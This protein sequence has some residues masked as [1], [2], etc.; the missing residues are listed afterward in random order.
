MLSVN[1]HLN[2]KEKKNEQT[3]RPC[4]KIEKKQKT[5]RGS[6]RRQFIPLF[7]VPLKPFRGT[8]ENGCMK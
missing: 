2:K 5:K 3:S 7:T 1:V 6:R 4:D 8:L